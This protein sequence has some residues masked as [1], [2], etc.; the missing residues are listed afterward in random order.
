MTTVLIVGAAAL[1]L[2]FCTVTLLRRRG[3][4]RG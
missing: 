3:R 1:L 2:C 4:S